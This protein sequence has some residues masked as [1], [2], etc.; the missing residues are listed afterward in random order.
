MMS[1]LRGLPIYSLLVPMTHVMGYC[2][3]APP[4]LVDRSSFTAFTKSDNAPL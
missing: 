1:P 3:S 4:G 2:Y